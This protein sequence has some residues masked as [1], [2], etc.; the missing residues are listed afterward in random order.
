MKHIYLDQFGNPEYLYR[1]AERP[2]T[3]F[4]DLDELMMSLVKSGRSGKVIILQ[5]VEYVRSPEETSFDRFGTEYVHSV[6]DMEDDW[7]IEMIRAQVEAE[8]EEV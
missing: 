2:N 6:I 1:D 7:R 4:T 5:M 8:E 3:F